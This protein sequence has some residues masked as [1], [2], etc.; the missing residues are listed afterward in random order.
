MDQLSEKFQG[1]IEKKENKEKNEIINESE[2][3]NN[4]KEKYFKQEKTLPSKVSNNI[5]LFNRI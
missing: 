2:I 5:Q 4:E 3:N 1:K